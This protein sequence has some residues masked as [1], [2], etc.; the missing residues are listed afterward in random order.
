MPRA[1]VRRLD[2]SAGA[3]PRLRDAQPRVPSQNLSGFDLALRQILAAQPVAA[4]PAALSSLALRCEN[5]CCPASV[6]HGRTR[7]VPITGPHTH[8][9]ALLMLTTRADG[10]VGG[11]DRRAGCRERGSTLGGVGGRAFVAPT[12]LGSG[13]GLWVVISRD[14]ADTLPHVSRRVIFIYRGLF[15]A[16]CRAYN[17]VRA[18]TRRTLLAAHTGIFRTKR[19]R[20]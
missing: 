2:P 8:R 16:G 4:Q 11:A 12:V 6:A 17:T 19:L 10:A 20:G 13:G 9:C 3:A 18:D 5:A 1:R 7:H 14:A 15:E